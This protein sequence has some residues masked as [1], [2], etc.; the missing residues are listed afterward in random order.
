MARLGCAF[1][2]RNFP[3]QHALRQHTEA[4]HSNNRISGATGRFEPEVC[5]MVPFPGARGR[6]VKKD[7]YQGRKGFG[8]FVCKSCSR[9]WISAHAFRE[10]YA[11]ECQGCDIRTFAYIMWQSSE[12]RVKDRDEGVEASGSPHDASRCDACRDG[13]YCT[14]IPTSTLPRI[15]TPSSTRTIPTPISVV[16]QRP[17]ILAPVTTQPS[18]WLPPPPIQTTPF[19][20]PTAAWPP[21][22]PPPI[23]S[24]TLPRITSP[25]HAPTSRRRIPTDISTTQPSF[26][27][28]SPTTAWPSPPPHMSTV[29][30]T[31]TM[32]ISSNYREQD[33]THSHAR[34]HAQSGGDAPLCTFCAVM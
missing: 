30:P 9:F 11:Q 13:N 22:P 18:D 34:A 2:N 4:K 33:V 5:E 23:E 28:S 29:R 8:I 1:C 15:T 27:T 14:K 26:S 16:Q 21:L 24:S 20:T 19:N 31:R 32:P 12:D 3:S 6:W 7:D 17:S 10:K 25:P